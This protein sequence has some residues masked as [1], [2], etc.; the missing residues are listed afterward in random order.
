MHTTDSPPK[1][2][3][4][5]SAEALFGCPLGCFLYVVA[6]AL[7]MACSPRRAEGIREVPDLPWRV[8]ASLPTV[9]AVTCLFVICFYV[10]RPRLGILMF[11][12]GA[13]AIAVC[14]YL[15]RGWLGRDFIGKC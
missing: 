1:R 5:T 10:R 11:I 9:L 12:A 2:E 4:V 15:G 7:T 13:V 8:F 14:T 6:A 3:R